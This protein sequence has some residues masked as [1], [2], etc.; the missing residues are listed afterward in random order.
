MIWICDEFALN[1]YQMQ[2]ISINRSQSSG[3]WEIDPKHKVCWTEESAKN[4]SSYNTFLLT[5]LTYILMA[6]AEAK[7]KIEKFFNKIKPKNEI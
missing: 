3:A 2:F 4:Q 1:H 7:R 6:I 5:E